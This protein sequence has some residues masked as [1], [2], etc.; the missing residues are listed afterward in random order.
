[1]KFNFVL[2]VFSCTASMEPYPHNLFASAIH[3]T[4]EEETFSISTK[5]AS[6]SASNLSWIVHSLNNDLLQELR[7]YLL[8]FGNH[9][10]P[11]KAKCLRHT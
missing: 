6:I 10:F 11:P 3:L 2:S 9:H 7:W 1:M 5:H 4:F 8:Q